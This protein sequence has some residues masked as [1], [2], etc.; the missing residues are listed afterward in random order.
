MYVLVIFATIVFFACS[1]NNSADITEKGEIVDTMKGTPV[2][3]NNKIHNNASSMS[4]AGLVI[5]TSGDI[6][7]INSK[8]YRNL[9]DTT[10][11]AMTRALKNYFKMSSSTMRYIRKS[12]YT[13]AQWDSMMQSELIS[14]RRTYL[15][16]WATCPAGPLGQINKRY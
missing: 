15:H 4:G 11:D 6:K 2:F 7:I 16:V 9:S 1:H 12:D 13:S 10:Q 8:M 3:T 5:T 14:G